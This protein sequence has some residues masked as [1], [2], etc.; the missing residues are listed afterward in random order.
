[1]P[2][3]FTRCCT[4]GGEFDAVGSITCEGIPAAIPG[5]ACSAPSSSHSS[6]NPIRSTRRPAGSDAVARTGATAGR[7]TATQAIDS[8]AK[9]AAMISPWCSSAA[10]NAVTTVGSSAFRP[11][12]IPGM[13]YK[14]LQRAQGP[15]G[16]VLR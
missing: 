2:A 12:F 4:Q 13:A 3:Q 11:L 10:R 16:R 9:I 6:P 14:H 8:T 5:C 7:R 15:P 1:M